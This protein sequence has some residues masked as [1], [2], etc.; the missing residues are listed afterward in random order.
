MKFIN[1]K[2]FQ[3]TGNI[4]SLSVVDELIEKKHIKTY[5]VDESNKYCITQD[6]E[7]YFAQKF[8]G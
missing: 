1:S 6:G 8:Q 7:E 5:L 2:L 4:A 3:A